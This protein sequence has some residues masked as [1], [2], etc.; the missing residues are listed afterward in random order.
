[1]SMFIIILLAASLALASAKFLKLP[2]APLL[3][4]AGGL[5][6]Y[7]NVSM[8]L[9]MAKDTLL[10]GLAFL[11]FYSG[12]SLNPLKKRDGKAFG[13]AF[14]LSQFFAVGG[15]AF[16]ICY[17]QGLGTLESLYLSL[18]AGS[19]S[20]LVAVKILQERGEMFEPFGRLLTSALLSKDLALVLLL[21]GLSGADDGLYSMASSCG[22]GLAL[23]LFS[24]FFK[25]RIAPWLLL[26]KGIDEEFQLLIALGVF[27]SFMGLADVFGL[28]FLVGA[29]LAGISLSAFP[30]SGLLKGQLES[31]H[32]FFSAVFFVV[33]G[34]FVNLPP[35]GQGTTVIA[36]CFA[37]ILATPLVSALIA[38][39]TGKTLRTGLEAGLLMAQASEFSIILG[40]VGLDNRHLGQGHLSMI[41]SMTVITMI[42]TPFISDPRFA[43]ALMRWSLKFAPHHK[44]A[45]GLSGHYLIIGCGE[46]SMEILKALLKM[47]ESV[48]VIDDD[49]GVTREVRELGGVGILAN[50][51]DPDALKEAGID[52]AKLV[53]SSMRK[54]TD[55]NTMM[56]FAPEVPKVIRVFDA[57][58]AE[59]FEGLGA[60]SIP[61]TE[62]ATSDLVNWVEKL[63]P[64]T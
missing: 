64:A 48:A 28:P 43:D 62:A 8:D 26:S 58:E 3:I 31:L 40:L 37:I 12:A 2:Q 21:A 33:L 18:A 53:I 17:F 23:Y 20:T 50:G 57:T 47:R 25:R 39:K 19:S 59:Y 49:A 32:H 63:A 15:I 35:L 54:V 41:T 34:Y 10:L 55:N 7:A 52:R 38:L 16:G 60:L 44:K 36:L 14:G 1:M 13:M 4:L 5:L 22:L 42:L 6:D 27:F 45:A 46:S 61:V 9:A 29:F 11:I 56:G 51:K 30:I 24:V